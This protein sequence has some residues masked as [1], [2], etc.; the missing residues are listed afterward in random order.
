M[1]KAKYLQQ[2]T[3]PQIFKSFKPIILI[4]FLSGSKGAGDTTKEQRGPSL[5]LSEFNKI[6]THCSTENIHLT[7][8]EVAWASERM[9]CNVH[10]QIIYMAS[11]Y[12]RWRLYNFWNGF[13]KDAFQALGHKLSQSNSHTRCFRKVSTRTLSLVPVRAKQCLCRKVLSVHPGEV[14]MGLESKYISRL[15]RLMRSATSLTNQNVVYAVP[16]SLNAMTKRC[17]SCKLLS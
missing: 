17:M 8:L 13:W 7:S 15:Q 2:E 6:P 1:N 5:W 4:H 11:K 10:L 9:Y 16:V 12:I 14:A 3:E